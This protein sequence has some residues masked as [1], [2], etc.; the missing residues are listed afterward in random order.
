M[1]SVNK[2]DL[3]YLDTNFYIAY[4]FGE[5]ND[6]G[7]TIPR[8][9]ENDKRQFQVAQEYF[10]GTT[11]IFFSYLVALEINSVIRAILSNRQGTTIE[12]LNDKTARLFQQIMNS[13]LSDGETNFIIEDSSREGTYNNNE[14]F[15]KAS[16][17]NTNVRGNFRTYDNCNKCNRPMQQ[18]IHKCVGVMDIIHAVNAKANRCNKFITFD[19]QFSELVNNS[20]LNPLEIEIV[21]ANKQM[22]R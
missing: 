8:V 2:G 18:R 20:E 17:I 12:F 16:Q 4:F 3:L 7:H 15:Q 13:I 11:R 14:L 1:N 10:N 6:L 19:K 21:N 5:K 9:V 22:F